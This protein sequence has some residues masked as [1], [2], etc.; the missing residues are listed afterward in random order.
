MDSL[1]ITTKQ[2]V[3]VNCLIFTLLGVSVSVSVFDM[4]ADVTA[5]I[6]ARALHDRQAVGD[7]IQIVALTQ[8]RG[9][10]SERPTQCN[11]VS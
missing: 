5:V 9:S 3:G 10:R 2:G 8:L 4:S 1:A 7:L 11:R 6:C